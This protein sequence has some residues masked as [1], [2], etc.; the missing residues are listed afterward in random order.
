MPPESSTAE[1]RIVNH[2]RPL[3]LCSLATPP[4]TTKS[5]FEIPRILRR[6]QDRAVLSQPPQQLL[7]LLTPRLQGDISFKA[8]ESPWGAHDVPSVP[9]AARE[10]YA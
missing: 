4:S 8:A 2:R 9:A 6:E 3:Q 5:S 1:P 10:R 7:L